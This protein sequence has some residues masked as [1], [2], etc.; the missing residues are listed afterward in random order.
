MTMFIIASYFN[1][2]I[3]DIWCMHTFVHLHLWWGL[4]DKNRF[5]VPF[6]LCGVVLIAHVRK[7][8]WNIPLVNEI[9]FSLK[10]LSQINT[11]VFFIFNVMVNICYVF[12]EYCSIL[13]LKPRMKIVIRGQK[14]K[15]KLISKSLSQTEVDVYKPT[16]L[17]SFYWTSLWSSVQ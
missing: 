11:I 6:P 8:T 16:W 2:I 7:T 13:Y 3:L 9:V 15:T 10:M 14:V 4:K 5:Y 1:D 17:V 12:Q